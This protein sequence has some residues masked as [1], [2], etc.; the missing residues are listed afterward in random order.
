MAI[1][2]LS[3]V[4]G[5]PDMTMGAEL[6][7]SRSRRRAV[8]E[9][10]RELPCPNGWFFLALSKELAPGRVLTRRLAD[11]DVVIYRTHDGRP[12]AVR[13][14]CPHLGA[15]LGA[16]GTVRDGNLVCPFHGFAFAPDGTCAST[17][18]GPPPRA[19]LERHTIRERN[20]LVFVWYA[21]DGSSPTWEIPETA[22]AGVTPT[23]FWST[24]VQA[25]VQELTENTLDLRHLPVVHH[26]RLR[27][28]AP[29]RAE[30]PC[31]H[32]R[33]RLGPARPAVLRKFQLD[34][35]FLL[36]GMGCLRIE[37][38][39]RPIGLVIFTWALHTPT[40]PGRTRLV[41]ATACA[42]LHRSRFAGM[43][44]LRRPLCRALARVL[45]WISVAQV[46][47]DVRIWNAKRY[48]PRPR[49]AAGDES[50]G[51]YRHWVRQFYPT[52]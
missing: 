22:G 24:E 4:V 42:E 31:V 43:S 33:L 32:T 38:P 11:E 50:I 41:L 17:P 37:Q 16:G 25:H 49:L 36:A 46:Q 45:L 44:L 27:V 28:L 21:S 1:R 10:E 2:G 6:P 30:G 7:E 34:H 40:A 48:E 9:G 51:L 29:S 12:H 20:G 47:G 35:A 13:P 8:D 14:Y 39:L 23:A 26:V 18:D 52:P 15:H 3:L 19:R 5:S